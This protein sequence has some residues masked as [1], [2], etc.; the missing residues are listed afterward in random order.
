MERKRVEREMNLYNLFIG[1]AI[2]LSYT[3]LVFGLSAIFLQPILKG[4]RFT[5]SFLACFLAGNF[6]IM[7]IVFLLLLFFHCANRAVTGFVLLLGALILRVLL[8]YKKAGQEIKAGWDKFFCLIAGTYGWRLFLK[9]IKQKL[10]GDFYKGSLF[11]ITKHQAEILGILLCLVIQAF[12]TGHRLV[13]Y[14]GYGGYDEVV[15]AS[16]IQNM[17]NNKIYSSGVYPFGFHEM[18]YSIAKVFNFHV[19]QVVRYFGF[20]IMIYMT[21]MLYCLIA[22]TLHNTIAAFVATF[23]YAGVNIY[24]QI[25]WDRCGFGFPQEFGALFLYPMIIFLFLYLKEKKRFF[26]LFFGMGFSLTLYVHYYITIIALLLCFSVG[27]VYAIYIFRKKLLLPILLCG[28]GASIIGAMTMVLGVA[29]GHELQG[30]LYWALNVISGEQRTEILEENEQEKVFENVQEISDSRNKESIKETEIW[31]NPIKNQKEQQEKK[32]IKQEKNGIQ[33]LYQEIHKARLSNCLTE[34]SFRM[35]LAF[36]IV[37]FL[38]AL[39]YILSGKDPFKGAFILAFLLYIFFLD[40]LMASDG[41]GLPVL[42]EDYRVRVFLCYALPYVLAVPI[43]TVVEVLT[44]FYGSAMKEQIFLQRISMI[45]IVVF[46]IVTLTRYELYRYPG[47][48]TVLQS[49]SIVDVFYQILRDYD[50]FTWTLVSDVQEYSLCMENGYHYEWIELLQKLSSGITDI[51]IPTKYI[52]FAIEKTPIAYGEVIENGDE[53]PVLGKVSEYY[54]KQGFTYNNDMA[55]IEE[56][57]QVMSK[58][59]YWAKAYAEKFPEEMQVYY[60]DENVIYYRLTQEIYYL[61]NLKIDYGYNAI[62]EEKGE[63]VQ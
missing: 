44:D 62:T 36:T 22:S 58:A 8:N 12:Y 23:I 55:Y 30:S 54:A 13:R 4:R 6:Y 50:D 42:I 26:L 10:F 49:D 14:S 1:T 3:I 35:F 31:Q 46:A 40:I 63:N 60:E 7:N 17:M 33:D 51:K 24:I 53:V 28:I 52:F 59:Y 37:S 15:H 47:R 39:G 9:E 57:L 43:L 2:F 19:P 32:E 5:V 21:L 11:I 27:I 29:T 61:N 34:N 16:W 56:R 18:V 45:P 38:L 48:T 20:I 41:L 25:A